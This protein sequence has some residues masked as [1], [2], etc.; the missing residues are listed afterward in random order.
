[1]SELE[2]GLKQEDL[3]ALKQ[4]VNDIAVKVLIDKL[5]D[6]YSKWLDTK[7]NPELRSQI[8]ELV[9]EIQVLLPDFEFRFS[10]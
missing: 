5:L 1:M 3:E 9:R 6:L 2:E 8:L 10:S 4:S 7:P